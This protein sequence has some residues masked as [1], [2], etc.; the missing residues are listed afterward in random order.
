M[1]WYTLPMGWGR[2]ITIGLV[3][4]AL[5]AE[6]YDWCGPAL[7]SLSVQRQST[8]RMGG[9]LE[10][11]NEYAQLVEDATALKDLVDDIDKAY[12]KLV[13]SKIQNQGLARSRAEELARGAI[14]LEAIRLAKPLLQEGLFDRYFGK[15][16]QKSELFG[17]DADS[18]GRLQQLVETRV[19]LGKSMDRLED[20]K[21]NELVELSPYQFKVYGEL[22]ENTAVPEPFRRDL[23]KYLLMAKMNA[24]LVPTPHFNTWAVFL[25]DW[26][27]AHPFAPRRR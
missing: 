21:E 20:L 17:I 6:A 12:V 27:R 11:P 19:L 10:K 3:L 15:D 23:E 14:H 4:L 9:L 18:L 2:G 13:D 16:W 5:R 8:G 7:V 22:V 1:G 24:G 25:T 26:A